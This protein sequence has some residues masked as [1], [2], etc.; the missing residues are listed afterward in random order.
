MYRREQPFEANGS[1]PVEFIR[2]G[3][4]IYNYIPAGQI[5]EIREDGEVIGR[6]GRGDASG[7]KT[8]DILSITVHLEPREHM[9]ELCRSGKVIAR[10][11]VDPREID[12]VSY[13]V[14]PANAFFERNGW[15]VDVSNYC[16]SLPIAVVTAPIGIIGTWIVRQ[17][18]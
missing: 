14:S 1:I 10:K 7:A 12:K 18:T 11:K 15:L 17:L 4:C 2:E 16:I 8:G 5:D 13:N 6:F 9:I 3:A